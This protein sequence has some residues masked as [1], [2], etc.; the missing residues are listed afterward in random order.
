M[1]YG[2][3]GEGIIVILSFLS[4]LFTLFGAISFDWKASGIVGRTQNMG[5]PIPEF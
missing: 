3:S 2:I 1:D 5:R 4:H